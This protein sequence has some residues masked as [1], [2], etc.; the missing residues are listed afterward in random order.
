[1]GFAL[2]M[3]SDS[4]LIMVLNSAYGDRNTLP[5][6][7]RHKAGPIIFTLQANAT[8]VDFQAV[9]TNLVNDLK[10]ALREIFSHIQ[11]KQ[12]DP[13]TVNYIR[14]RSKDDPG[15]YYKPDEVLATRPWAREADGKCI[16][17]ETPITY[18]RV[19][20]IK[21]APQLKRSEA[22]ELARNLAVFNSRAMGR[23]S[24]SN[25]YGGI[26]YHAIPDS[27]QLLTASQLF[28]N[29]EIWGFEADILHPE[30][31]LRPEGVIGIPTGY[32]ERNFAE[33]LHTYL[34]FMKEQLKIDPPY[35]IEAGAIGCKG[36]VLF[37]PH[38]FYDRHWGP[39]L[40]DNIQWQGEIND[41]DPST[42]D[43]TLLAIFEEFFDAAACKRPIK[44]NGFPSN[45]P[46]IL[47]HR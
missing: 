21:N 5:F 39:V 17:P 16:G 37:M 4:R 43:N 9:K 3:L 6:D 42:I 34:K 26:S 7:L 15:R 33:A 20:P 24:G 12:A 13:L 40:Q 19:T 35:R 23:S 14:G 18:L 29:R 46:G 44:F 27:P 22:E 38:N 32:L 10:V 11:V 31:P 45:I 30:H 25:I 41:L 36:Y 47:P 8:K 28:L 2:G 1:L